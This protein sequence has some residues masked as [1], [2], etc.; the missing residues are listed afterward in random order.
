MQDPLVHHGCHFGHVVHAFCNVQ[1][2]LTNGITLM[3]EVEERGLETLTQEDRKEYSTFQELLKI[4]P[5]LED[6]LM[7]SSE[8]EVIAMVELL[9]ASG[10]R[11]DD[12]K[13]IKAA[14]IDWITPKG[15]ALIP[16]IP[17]NHTGTLLCP[18]GYEWANSK[19]KAKLHSG[20]LQVAGDQWPLYLYVDYSYDTED[21][22]N[23]L[24]HNGFLQCA[25]RHIF[26]SPSSVDQVPKA[27]QSGNAH[28]HG[29]QTARFALTSMY[30]SVL[31]DDLVTDSERFYT[32]IL[33][34]LEDPDEIDEVGQLIGWWNHIIIQP[35][36][37]CEQNCKYIWAIG[38]SCQW[39][40]GE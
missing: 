5:N 34:L 39:D 20:Q 4:V 31:S 25:Y 33:E 7:S 29:M 23:G 30:P 18:A 6:C 26:T 9:S 27:T 13:S 19:T 14:I 36:I 3:G 24:L 11:G 35:W 21:P 12:T 1:T 10:A 16:H 38:A 17:R 15:Q 8:E 28:I 22:W 2:L 32:S 37:W 40:Q